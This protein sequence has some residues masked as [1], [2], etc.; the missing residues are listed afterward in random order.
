MSSIS[1]FPHTPTTNNQNRL[2]H[3]GNKKKNKIKFILKYL[4]K[5]FVVVADFLDVN[6]EFGVHVRLHSAV[7]LKIKEHTDDNIYVDNNK[8]RKK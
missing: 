4:H 5:G 3:P 1:L 6:V 2:R 8:E 7:I